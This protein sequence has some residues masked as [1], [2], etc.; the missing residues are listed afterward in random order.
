MARKTEEPKLHYRDLIYVFIQEYS[1]IS[2]FFSSDKKYEALILELGKHNQKSEDLP[3]QKDLLKVLNLPRTD[4]ISLMNDLYSDFD[5]RLGDTNAYLMAKT[6]ISLILSSFDKVW[7]V[8]V[9]QLEVIPRIGETMLLTFIR[10]AYGPG[11]F[12]V[13]D[14]IHE[15]QDGVHRIEV[16]LRSTL[17]IKEKSEVI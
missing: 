13:E 15:I 14:I 5:M 10:D 6:E 3:F 16:H 12:I 2:R 1:T 11:Y 9:N 4:L 7:V 17:E 8:G